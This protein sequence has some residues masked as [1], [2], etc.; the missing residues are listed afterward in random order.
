MTGKA[1]LIHSDALSN[2]KGIASFT[3]GHDCSRG[4]GEGG[5][6]VSTLPVSMC[7]KLKDM[8]PFLA[9]TSSE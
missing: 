3:L 4:G 1:E 5:D 7:R 9:S 8:G 2:G 6:L